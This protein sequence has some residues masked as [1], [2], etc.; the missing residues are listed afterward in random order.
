MARKKKKSSCLRTLIALPLIPFAIIVE[1]AKDYK[2]MNS[3]G[4]K[5]SRAKKKKWF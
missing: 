2:P 4:R 3:K 1:S 5:I